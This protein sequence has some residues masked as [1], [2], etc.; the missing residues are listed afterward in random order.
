MAASTEEVSSM[1]ESLAAAVEQNAASITQMA[2]SVESVAQSGRRIADAATGAATSA[3]QL[4][5][6]VHAVAGLGRQA[7]EVTRRVSRDAEEGAATVQKSMQSIGRLREA[8]TQSVSVTREMSKRT[9]DISGIVSTI[10]TIAERTNLLSL[11]A[12][13]EAARAGEAGRGF[14]VVANEVKE[15]ARE[16]ASATEDIRHR[17]EAIQQDSRKA[18]ESIA[19]ISGIVTSIHDIQATIAAAVDQQ[20]ATTAEIGRNITE[21]AQ[22]SSEIAAGVTGVARAAEG[23]ARGAEATLA[24]AASLAEMSAEL[25]RTVGQFRFD[26]GR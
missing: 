26:T 2:R 23:T 21:A 17:I 12:S 20:T 18:I 15:L 8:M 19:E 4:D 11:N 5:R 7:A 22:G 25:Q 9:T 14:A 16:T 24:A 13:I 3:A 10:S 1:A 6:S